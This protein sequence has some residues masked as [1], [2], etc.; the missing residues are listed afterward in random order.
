MAVV[1]I[2]GACQEGDDSEV[3]LEV[4][5][6]VVGVEGSHVATDLVKEIVEGIA[7]AEGGVGH[8]EGA[9]GLIAE[10]AQRHHEASHKEHQDSHP[11][12]NLL[13]I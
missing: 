5:V 10:A 3:G 9:L 11:I 12:V 8:V 7:F 1:V 2:V 6:G 13:M 4:G